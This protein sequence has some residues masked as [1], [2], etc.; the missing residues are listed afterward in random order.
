LKQAH[1]AAWV[2]V[3]EN[4]VRNELLETRILLH[5]RSGAIA[6]VL[7]I[8]QT[9]EVALGIAAESLEMTQGVKDRRGDDENVFRGNCGHGRSLPGEN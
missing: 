8:E 6:R 3:A 9:F 2:A 5:C 1:A 7:R 4:D